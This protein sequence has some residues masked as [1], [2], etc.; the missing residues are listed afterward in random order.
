MAATITHLE[1]RE[2]QW[3]FKFRPDTDE[4]F[5][6]TLRTFKQHIPIAERE[7]L[8]SQS[9]WAVLRTDKNRERLASLFPNFEAEL[10]ILHDQLSLFTVS[11]QE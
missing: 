5:V 11:T 6:I 1:E 9:R 7:W 10:R 2:Q 3:Y 4:H 8:E